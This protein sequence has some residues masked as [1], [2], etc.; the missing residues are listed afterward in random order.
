MH[1][2]IPG[3]KRPRIRC[4]ECAGGAPPDLP[5]LHEAGGIEPTGFTKASSHGPKRTRGE[6]RA[7][8]EKWSP[9]WEAE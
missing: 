6:F 2:T 9:Y 7:Y 3:V 1:I 5:A 4:Q 8:V